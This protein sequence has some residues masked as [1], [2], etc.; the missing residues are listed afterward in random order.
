MSLSNG[1]VWCTLKHAIKHQ[2]DKVEEKEEEEDLEK[3]NNYGHRGI[4]AL[5][6]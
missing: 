1:G 6:A 2:V 3:G 4:I 5:L